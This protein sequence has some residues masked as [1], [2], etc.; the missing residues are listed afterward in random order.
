MLEVLFD[1]LYTGMCSLLLSVSED[2]LD[3][4]KQLKMSEFTE[5]VEHETEI[6]TKWRQL[7]PNV[8]TSVKG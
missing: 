4:A 5:I 2:I 7:K 8:E 1:F 6:F 3:V